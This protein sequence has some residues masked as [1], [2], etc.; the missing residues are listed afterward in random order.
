MMDS[1]L[2]YQAL[3]RAKQLLEQRGPAP[4]PVEM[5]IISDDDFD[6]TVAQFT[7]LG[8]MVVP[9]LI[10]FDDD[11]QPVDMLDDGHQ[12]MVI[13]FS[14]SPGGAQETRLLAFDDFPADK[15]LII[16]KPDPVVFNRFEIDTRKDKRLTMWDQYINV[17]L[18]FDDCDVPPALPDA[19]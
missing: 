10:K 2:N 16:N 5:Y 12:Y 19:Y 7:K 4:K 3:L 15:I 14:A 13:D 8:M 6:Q 17:C 18:G 11:G 1:N 9:Y